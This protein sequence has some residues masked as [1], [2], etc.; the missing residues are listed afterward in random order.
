MNVMNMHVRSRTYT[1]TH[2]HTHTHTQAL[3]WADGEF[4]DRNS[5]LRLLRCKAEL[6]RSMG[7]LLQ[8]RQRLKAKVS[9][10]AFPFYY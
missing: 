3:V 7:V 5:V 4:E 8:L 6:Q 9:G 1:H 2:T 10:D